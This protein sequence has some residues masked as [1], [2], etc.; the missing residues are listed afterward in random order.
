[1]T[2]IALL[3]I[4]LCFCSPAWAED[5]C[6][7]PKLSDECI[8]RM[9]AAPDADARP[10]ALY[11]NWNGE[12]ISSYFPTFDECQEGAHANVAHPEFFTCKQ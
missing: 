3:L 10:W 9:K 1:M 5:D 2:R 8:S 11:Q 7:G 6:R 4:A 12:R